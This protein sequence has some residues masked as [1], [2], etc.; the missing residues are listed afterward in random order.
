MSK[1]LWRL[2]SREN[3]LCRSPAHLTSLP[4]LED[5]STLG[6]SVERP[7]TN[8]WMAAW[9]FAVSALYHCAFPRPHCGYLEL[10]FTSLPSQD[11]RGQKPTWHIFIV[12]QRQQK[13]SSYF[14]S[15][16]FFHFHVCEHSHVCR[17]RCGC[18]C[19]TL[20][21]A[22][23]LKCFK[24]FALSKNLAGNSHWKQ[25]FYE[26]LLAKHN[27]RESKAPILEMLAVWHQSQI[28]HRKEK[29]YLS[30]VVANGPRV[31]MRWCVWSRHCEPSLLLFSVFQVSMGRLW[32]AEELQGGPQLLPPVIS[33]VAKRANLARAY[34]F[35]VSVDLAV[36]MVLP[37]W[38]VSLSWGVSLTG[39][40][41]TTVSW[42]TGMTSSSA[43]CWPR[44]CLA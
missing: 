19:L 1:P 44:C 10:I 34:L 33:L 7:A 8:A 25:S 27:Y 9:V 43:P 28:C 30:S 5:P 4:T 32:R 16:S 13:S 29:G 41:R 24:S 17:H 42:V 3:A 31:L 20:M 37:S 23:V 39:M 40:G 2:S 21:L 22:T 11:S 14:S 6:E 18:A 35:L 12:P 36:L 26:T 15:L 38:A